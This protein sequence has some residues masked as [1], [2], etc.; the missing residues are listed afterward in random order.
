M[1]KRFPIR[2]RGI[3]SRIEPSRSD[4]LAKGSSST[5]IAL[6]LSLTKEQVTALEVLEGLR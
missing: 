3:L 6:P 1:A 5:S 2:A 4:S